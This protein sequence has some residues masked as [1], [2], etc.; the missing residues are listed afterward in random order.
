[1][2]GHSVRRWQAEAQSRRGVPFRAP[3]RR[4]PGDDGRTS[5]AARRVPMIE[6]MKR[7]LDLHFGAV[8][9]GVFVDQIG[10][11]AMGAA[12]AIIAAGAVGKGGLEA[13]SGT[14]NLI[15]ALYEASC[16][17]FGVIGAFTAARLAR[18][19]MVA[20]GIATSMTSLGVSTALG[21]AMN[22]EMFDARGIFFAVVALVAGPLGGWLASLLPVRRP[23]AIESR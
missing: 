16:I 14:G 22:Q 9:V 5:P 6:T 18:R 23:A 20:H 7:G 8:I 1:M 10:S 19:S 2:D 13:A 21:V 15:Q 17:V 12:I 3:R 4:L 11:F